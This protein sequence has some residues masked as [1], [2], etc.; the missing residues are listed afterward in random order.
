MFSFQKK[1]MKMK[2]LMK[3][4]EKKNHILG[5][6][7]LY[8]HPTSGGVLYYLIPDEFNDI[9]KSDSDFEIGHWGTP[10]IKY[11]T[12]Y[13]DKDRHGSLKGKPYI[14]YFGKKELN[15]KPKKHNIYEYKDMYYYEY[16]SSDIPKEIEYFFE[17]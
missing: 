17:N 13:Y 3:F 15:F 10:F 4:N 5:D 12:T 9:L 1:N 6:F 2:Y 14:Q 16:D 8:L 11:L 7:H